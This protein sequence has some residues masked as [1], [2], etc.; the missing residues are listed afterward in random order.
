MI[1]PYFD[2]RKELFPLKS[3]RTRYKVMLIILTENY[4][5]ISIVCN[6]SKDV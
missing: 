2:D 3:R 1:F 6:L 4:L 5:N